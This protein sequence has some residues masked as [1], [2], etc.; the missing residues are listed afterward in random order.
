MQKVMSY[1][2]ETPAV[3]RFSQ[4]YGPDWGRLPIADRLQIIVA[5]GHHAIELDSGISNG[6]GLPYLATWD[7]HQF[8]QHRTVVRGLEQLSGELNTVGSVGNLIIG[9]CSNLY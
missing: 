9:I 4:L 1:Y 7:G 5:L 6:S 2:L 8:H 3:Q